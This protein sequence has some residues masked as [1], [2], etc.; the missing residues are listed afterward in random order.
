[1]RIGILTYH[2]VP[3]FGAQL[4]ATSTV[5]FIRRMGHEPIVLHWYPKDLE[6]MYN[7][8][9][10]AEQ[11]EAH[12]LYTEQILPVTCLIRTEEELLDVIDHCNLDG[13]IV[14]SDALFKF[15]PEKFRKIFSI[16]KLRYVKKNITSVEKL[17]NNPFFGGFVSRMKRKIPV[18]AFSVS[19][20]NCPYFAMNRDERE[21]MAA[22]MSNFSYITVRD[23]WTKEMVETITNSCS[24]E[25]TPDPVFSFNQNNYIYLPT[26]K[27]VLERYGL[28]DKYVLLSFDKKWVPETYIN[29]IAE[30]CKRKGF[31]PVIFPTPENTFPVGKE[32]T[33]PHPISPIDWYALIKHS[34]GYIG[35]RMHPIVVCLHNAVPFFSIDQY[36]T[37]KNIFWG[38]KK[39]FVQNSS[40][41]FLILEQA[42]MTDWYH[43]FKQDPTCPSPTEVLEKIEK[44]DFEK[45]KTFSNLYQLQY[46]KAMN[47]VMS[48]LMS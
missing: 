43:S 47:R 37:F 26:K 16:R 32:K 19:S 13:I 10:S 18:V 25:I 29:C 14:G 35:E 9:V 12:R 15:V 42:E 11:L 22:A 24:V 33:I 40:K 27:E 38:I 3:N 8:H 46:E 17:E 7:K 4:Q 34:S 1:M 39:Q 5:G 28:E 20:Q 36:G 44:F 31:Q 30:Q 6:S 21:G 48:Y 23:Q 45:C 41:T 2:C